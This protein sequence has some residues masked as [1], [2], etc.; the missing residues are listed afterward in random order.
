[1]FIP[2]EFDWAAGRGYSRMPAFP[3]QHKDKITGGYRGGKGVVGINPDM[4]NH[5]LG[6]NPGD[7]VSPGWTKSQQLYL[8]TKGKIGHGHYKG[9]VYVGVRSHPL[10]KNPGDVVSL[11]ESM[12]YKGKTQL[13]Q[14]KNLG[15]DVGLAEFRDR[16]RELGIPEGHLLGKNPGDVMNLVS[17]TRSK[18]KLLRQRRRD[19]AEMRK[20]GR[21]H[22]ELHPSK[23]PRWFN[24]KGKNPTDFWDIRPKPFPSAHFAVYPETLCIAPIKS[25]CPP[26]GVVLDPFAGSGTTVKVALELGRNA[27]GIE[28]NS[29]YAEIVQS[30]VNNIRVISCL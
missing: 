2:F 24:A 30:R 7:V 29:R 11:D 23:D 26:G 10:G 25:S 13:R 15:G 21:I 9:G 17:E 22:W 5:P 18:D 19:L 4:R 27:I 8:D 6:K 14:D 16:C 28:L 1:M 20:Q 3:P 12:K